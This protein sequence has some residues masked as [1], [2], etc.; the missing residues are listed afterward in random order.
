MDACMTELFGREDMPDKKRNYDSDTL[1][2]ANLNLRQNQ[3]PDSLNSRDRSKRK[4]STWK[5]GQKDSKFTYDL[6]Q[7][8]IEKMKD[9]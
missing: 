7:R 3:V 1:S 6:I 4:G 5:T 9:A 2:I 8:I